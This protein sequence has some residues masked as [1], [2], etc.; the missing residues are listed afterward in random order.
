VSVS[1]QAQGATQD[2]GGCTCGGDGSGGCGELGDQSAGKKSNALRAQQAG[3][4]AGPAELLTLS[5]AAAAALY[6]ATSE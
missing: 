3:R 5:A 6:R 4:D 1:D 2:D